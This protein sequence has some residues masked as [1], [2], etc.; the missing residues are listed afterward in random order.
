MLAVIDFRH[1]VAFLPP[2]PLALDVS[3]V[4]PVPL[5]QSDQRCLD[6]VH[7]HLLQDTDILWG[8]DNAG[9]E[10]SLI[11]GYSSSADTADIVTA[12]NLIIHRLGARV[13]WFHV[14]S[15]SNPSDGLSRDGISDPWIAEQA[16][17]NK[18]VLKEIRMPD[19]S[20]LSELPFRLLTDRL[21][22]LCS[23]NGH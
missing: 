1:L 13:W 16:T 14:D 10:A 5:R 7:P 21:W 4:F 12:V 17:K 22:Q 2:A 9:A 3:V 15:N 18:W 19:V 6:R 11:K 23:D 20:G 8:I